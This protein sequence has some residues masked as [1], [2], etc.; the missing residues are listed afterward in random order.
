MGIGVET[1]N[2]VSGLRGNRDGRFCVLAFVGSDGASR[3]L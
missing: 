3:R 2:T 1:Y